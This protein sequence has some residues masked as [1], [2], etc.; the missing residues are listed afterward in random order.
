MTASGAHAQV[1]L[2]PFYEVGWWAREMKRDYKWTLRKLRS[3]GVVSEF[4]GG[5]VVYTADLRE[6]APK[7]YDWLYDRELGRV[8][9]GETS[10]RVS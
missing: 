6:R 8:L 10:K 2:R 7:L 5:L 1:E 4:G 3:V 9:K